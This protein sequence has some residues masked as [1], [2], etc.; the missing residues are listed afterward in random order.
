[1]L[2]DVA[3]GTPCSE[4]RPAH[5]VYS[6]ISEGSWLLGSQQLPNWSILNP[7]GELQIDGILAQ[8]FQEL[9]H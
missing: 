9:F 2:F 6:V 5:F 4:L 8:F 7:L 1:M 3:L